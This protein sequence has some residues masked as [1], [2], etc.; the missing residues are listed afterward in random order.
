MIFVG[1]FTACGLEISI[2][3]ERLT[4]EKEGTM[5]KFVDQVEHVTFSGPYAVSK[6]QTV[7]YITERLQKWQEN[8]EARSR[9]PPLASPEPFAESSVQKIRQDFRSV[10]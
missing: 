9:R 10:P 5:H 8:R 6:G 3:D 7:L 2:K 1:T 4:I